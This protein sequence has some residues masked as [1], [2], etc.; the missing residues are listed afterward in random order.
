VIRVSTAICRAIYHGH[1]AWLVGGFRTMPF[2]SSYSICGRFFVL[3][4]V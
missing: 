2:K 4:S 1:R 3:C